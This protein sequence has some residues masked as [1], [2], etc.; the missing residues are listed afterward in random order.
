[1]TNIKHTGLSWF[2]KFEASQRE[3]AVQFLKEIGRLALLAAIPLFI[4]AFGDGVITA[5]E[6]VA[7]YVASGI[8]VLKGIDRALHETKVAEKGLLRF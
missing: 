7:I 8:A 4:T 2:D 1:M 3:F 5:A 6:W